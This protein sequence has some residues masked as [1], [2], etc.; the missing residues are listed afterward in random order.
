MSFKLIV[1][2]EVCRDFSSLATLYDYLDT[3]ATPSANL[4]GRPPILPQYAVWDG[5]AIYDANWLDNQPIPRP[6]DPAYK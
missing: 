6:S 5:D 4:I 1:R 3:L 2:G